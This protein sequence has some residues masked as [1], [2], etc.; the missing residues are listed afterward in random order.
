VEWLLAW[1]RLYMLDTKGMNEGRLFFFRKTDRV[2]PFGWLLVV[3]IL[4]G[5]QGIMAADST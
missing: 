4:K 5:W 1:R 2:S 3:I